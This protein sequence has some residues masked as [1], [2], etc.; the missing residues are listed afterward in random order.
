MTHVFRTY[1]GKPPKVKSEGGPAK[2]GRSSRISDVVDRLN[3]IAPGL[4]GDDVEE[5][6]AEFPDDAIAALEAI[7]DQLEKTPPTEQPD[8][9]AA[10]P[11]KATPPHPKAPGPPTPPPPA[12][13]QRRVPP[14]INLQQRI[15]EAREREAAMKAGRGRE[16]LKQR[17]LNAIKKPLGH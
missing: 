17:M 14:P 7:A 3:A 13:A 1:A 6:L 11:T 2:G 4:L 5:E 16:G 8:D 10:P 12:A 15:L 9:P